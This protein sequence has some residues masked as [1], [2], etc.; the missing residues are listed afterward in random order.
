MTKPSTNS[1]VPRVPRVKGLPFVGSLPA[2]LFGQFRFLE[3]SLETYGR[4]F[5]LDLGVTS[6]TIV[7]DPEAAATVLV[8][9]ASN[10]DKGEEFWKGGRELLGYGLGLSEGD[11]WR[12]Q[13]KLMQPV[14][15]Q[16]LVESY[17]SMIEETVAQEL[18]RLPLGK[19][20]DFGDWSNALLSLLTIRILFGSKLTLSDVDELRLSISDLFQAVL[21]G[22]VLRKLPPWLPRPGQRRLDEA[23]KA[24]DAN[25]LR[26][27]ADGRR[28]PN[29][30]NDLLRILIRATDESGVMSDQ[31]L[32][33]E[34][35]L[36]YL[37]GYETSG[38]ALGWILW[39]LARHPKIR[40]ELQA[41]LEADNRT[42]LRACIQEGLR[43]YPPGGLIPR[44]AVTD[45]VVGGFSIP[46]GTSVLVAPWLIHHDP[47][48]WPRP[49]DFEPKR[50][51][52]SEA[53]QR[54]RLA[55]VPFGAGQRL[56]IGKGLAML[57]LETAVE[58]FLRRFVPKQIDIGALPEPRLSTTLKPSKGL[59]L[60]LEP[61]AMRPPGE[62]RTSAGTG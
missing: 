20:I 60:S 35:V 33:D 29:A 58:M 30:D 3:Q 53:P 51:M 36:I 62:S 22:M 32:R 16:R 5:E 45:D 1:Y 48:L 37:G 27:I 11:L 4:I 46:G 24:V 28:R 57:E 55:W 10:F 47:S 61:C 49:H 39:L 14:F 40:S 26:L 6:V 12:R 25:I 43:M 41:E 44:R 18:D 42:L 9:K 13:R 19:P 21:P 50:F 59:F 17:R 15:Q 38:V 52:D 34:A 31:Q 7:A 54:P 56:C 8:D 2:L 23:R